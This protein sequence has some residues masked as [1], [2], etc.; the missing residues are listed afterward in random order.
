[1]DDVALKNRYA[2]STTTREAH[3]D[4]SG[5]KHKATSLTTPAPA[6]RLDL[7]GLTTPM[8]LN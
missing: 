2:N 3:T 6:T 1:V 7:W 8:P 4:R 5:G